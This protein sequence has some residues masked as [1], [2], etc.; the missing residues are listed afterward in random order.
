MSRASS[1]PRRVSVGGTNRSPAS[2]DRAQ[3]AAIGE[4]LLVAVVVAAGTAGYAVVGG[5]GTGEETLAD[6]AASADAG[7]V[8]AVVTHRGGDPI[9]AGDLRVLV[10]VNGSTPSARARDDAA[11]S[12]AADGR[13]DPGDVWAY[14]LGG[15]VAGDA[16]LR[17]VVVDESTATVVL[18]RAF[19]PAT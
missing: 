9:R 5:V 7:A 15:A 16:V 19:E 18:D 3:S 13:F 11:S 2:D 14:D 8:R 6:V 4:V 17:V 12:G 10:G 1:R